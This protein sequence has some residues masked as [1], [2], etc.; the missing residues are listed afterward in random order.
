MLNDA[1]RLIRVFHNLKQGALAERLG[2][3]QSHLSEIESG[4]KQPTLEVLRQY[5]EVFGMP[6]SS[7][8]FFAERQGQNGASAMENA[9]AQKTI[10]MLNWVDVITDGE[11]HR[12]VREGI[13]D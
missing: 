13:S 11:K 2:I 4:R 12:A 6:V 10:Q 1:L 7:I 8:I 3:S 9:I 5:A